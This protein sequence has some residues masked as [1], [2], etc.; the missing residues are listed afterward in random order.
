MGVGFWKLLSKYRMPASG[1]GALQSFRDVSQG[2]KEM[3]LWEKCYCLSEPMSWVPSLASLSFGLFFFLPILKAAK[4]HCQICLASR[5]M[6]IEDGELKRAFLDRAFHTFKK[7]C[8]IS[9]GERR[10]GDERVSP[11]LLGSLDCSFR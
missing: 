9:W 1:G 5:F 10:G 8:G 2:G 7:I 6:F 4:G 11:D 3:L